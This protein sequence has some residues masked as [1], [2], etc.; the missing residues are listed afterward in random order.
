MRLGIMQPYFFP[1]IGYFQLINAVDKFIMY[2]DLDFI[3]EAWVNRNKILIKNVGPSWITMPLV[4]KSSNAKINDIVID[5][6]KRW[7][8]NIKKTLELN[9]GRAPMFEMA[10][11]L[12]SDILNNETQSLSDFNYHSIHK[13]S[14]YIG[15]KTPMVRNDE[16]YLSIERKLEENSIKTNYKNLDDTVIEKKVLRVF[17]ICKYNKADVF[18]NAIG[19][20]EL[21]SKSLFA[22]NGLDVRFVKTD[23]I[24]YKQFGPIFYPSLSII[25]VMM[26]NNTDTINQMLSRY[27]FI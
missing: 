11:A 23:T 22:A 17:E 14:T 8:N 18:I 7:Q 4:K 5:N 26:F 2:D 6:T 20:R 24:A 16:I 1:Y 19:G 12:V 21:Y 13:I 9:Y 10:F 27:E 25:D 15:I 3:K